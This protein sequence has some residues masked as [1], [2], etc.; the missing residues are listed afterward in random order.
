[1]LLW[2]KRIIITLTLLL[3]VLLAFLRFQ[4]WQYIAAYS[5]GGFARSLPDAASIAKNQSCNIQPLQVLSYNVMYGSAFIEAMAARFRHDG[6]GKGEL[7]WSV[8]LPEIRE[9]IA[10]FAPDLLG[11]QEMDADTDIAAIVPLSQYTLVSYHLGNFQYGD[12]ALLF[13]TE[14]FEPLDAGQMWLGKTPDLPMS[15]G[16][17]PLSMIRYVNWALLREKASGFTFMFVNTHFDNA[18]ANKEPSAT[19]FRQRIASLTTKGLPVIVT[20]DFNTTANTERYRRFT[21]TDLQPSLLENAYVLAHSPPVDA[22]L[23]PDHRIDHILAGGPCK[24]EAEQWSID[25]RP[26]KNGL[27]MSDHDPVFA[28]LRF[29]DNPVSQ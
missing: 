25:P 21:G 3:S 9:R 18:A 19:L 4:G 7:P 13:K 28:R 14:R 22:V 26:L 2:F 17:R 23:H 24:V 20:G 16:Y 6:T 8:R 29:I 5:G 10:S 11:L 1:M 27:P 15:L 12:S